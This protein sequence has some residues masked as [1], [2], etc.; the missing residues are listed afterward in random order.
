MKLTVRVVIEK[1]LHSGGHISEYV[2]GEEDDDEEGAEVA[3]AGHGDSVEAG[4]GHSVEQE[5]DDQTDDVHD[6]DAEHE[7]HQPLLVAEDDG[8]GQPLEGVLGG[9][10]HGVAMPPRH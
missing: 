2:R 4:G 7:H 1:Q 8:V 5:D 3:A 10:D 9:L 6:A